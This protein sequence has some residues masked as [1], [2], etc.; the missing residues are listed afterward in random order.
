MIPSNPY[1]RAQF[2]GDLRSIPADVRA[3]WARARRRRQARRRIVRQAGVMLVIILIVG[4]LGL[5]D[6][7][8]GGEGPAYQPA[9]RS[10]EAVHG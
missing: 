1:L 9:P 7:L 6:G 8:V 3:E 10:I 4:L 5:L 2:L